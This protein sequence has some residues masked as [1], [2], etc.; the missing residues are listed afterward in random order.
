MKYYLIPNEKLAIACFCRSKLASYENSEVYAV[1]KATLEKFFPDYTIW[2]KTT[3]V[4]PLPVRNRVREL[5][6]AEKLQAEIL[7][8]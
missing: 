7:S 2:E 3:F 4:K 8:I 6:E 5:V 1:N